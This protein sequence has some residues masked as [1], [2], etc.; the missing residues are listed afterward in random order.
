MA[1]VLHD[2]Q[3][4]ILK[5]I[6]ELYIKNEKPVSSDEVL[7]NSN[8]KASS[9]TIRNDMQKLQKL[10]YIYQQHSSGGRIPTNP[11]LK[12]YFQMIK[13]A[14]NQEDTHIE[15]P[16]KYKFYDL[17]LMFQSLS[18]LL[19]NTLEGLVIFEYP[20]P[21]YVY[22]TRVT[23]TPLMEANNVITILTNLGLAVS[24]T[25]EIYGLPPSTELENILNNGL[26]GKSFHSLFMF[27]SAPKFETED[28]RVTNFIEILG[29]LTS[30]FNRKKYI[31]SGLEK[32]ISQSIPDLEAIE[33]LA[34]M[35]END[36]IKEGI[37]K[38]LDFTDDIEILF[39]EDLNSKAL[40]KMVFF[41]TTYKL[42][43]DPLGRVLF[44]TQKYCNY[45]KN[46]YFLREYI[47]RLSEII[48]KNL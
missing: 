31:I 29:H 48:S 13:D 43:A 46:Y 39:G 33:T 28:L 9:A 35:V 18:E 45:E 27:L 44:I 40:K 11:A 16:K 36:T 8:I 17:N 22:I 5:T 14:Y 4:E 23:V 41:Y 20:N 21:K 25:V 37:F 7:E 26:V 10:G 34:S 30:E 12:I 2:R 15:I 38:L 47:S 19:A 32:I 6:V 42:N 24:R 1:K 3:K